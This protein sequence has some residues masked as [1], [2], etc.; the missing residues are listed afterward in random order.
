MPQLDPTR[1]LCKD[2]NVTVSGI[3]KLLKQLSPT[4]AS[5][6]C[7][8]DCPITNPDLQSLYEIWHRTKVLEICPRR[9]RVQERGT[10]Q[11]WILEYSEVRIPIRQQPSPS[12]VSQASGSGIRDQS[13]VFVKDA[14]EEIEEG[15]KYTLEI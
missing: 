14:E 9:T 10:M 8:R 5:G 3:G 7:I 11:A 15:G 2:I 13:R 1:P 6:D 12:I 4:K